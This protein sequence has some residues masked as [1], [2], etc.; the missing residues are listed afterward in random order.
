MVMSALFAEAKTRF[1]M[2]GI[3][4]GIAV[5]ADIIFR[6]FKAISYLIWRQERNE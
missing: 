1:M 4:T 5:A 3:E 2:N 6:V